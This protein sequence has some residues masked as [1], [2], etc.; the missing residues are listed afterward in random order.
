M[1]SRV[2]RA[3]EHVCYMFCT[4]AMATVFTPPGSSYRGLVIPHLRH[5]DGLPDK[6]CLVAAMHAVKVAVWTTV[7]IKNNSSVSCYSFPTCP[8]LPSLPLPQYILPYLRTMNSFCV[9]CATL[10][11]EFIYH[12]AVATINHGVT[13]HARCLKCCVLLHWLYA[14][15]AVTLH[16][17][18]FLQ[19]HAH[20]PDSCYLC[21]CP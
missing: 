18:P 2:R 1:H 15:A 5:S 4:V 6:T 21:C 10:R 20:L 3:I 14:C 7:H 9:S 13:C 19:L 17:A 16:R 12:I 8:S 11:C